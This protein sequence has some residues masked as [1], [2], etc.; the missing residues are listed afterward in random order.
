LSKNSMIIQCAGCGTRFKFDETLIRGEGVW[1]RCSQCKNVFFQENVLAPGQVQMVEEPAAS[2]DEHA[3]DLPDRDAA[4]FIA[5]K[6]RKDHGTLKKVAL[7]ACLLLLILAG[8]MVWLTPG[9]LLNALPGGS[10]V[11]QY[12]S[13]GASRPSSSVGIDLID[14]RDH[15]IKS[16]QGGDLMVVSGTAV[17]RNGYPVSKLRVRA[18]LLNAAGQS[19]GEAES[20]G[21]NVL[22]DENLSKLTAKEIREKLSVSPGSDAANAK[23]APGGQVPFRIVFVDPPKSA[24]EFIV[25]TASLERAKAN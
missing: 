24:V 11:A 6:G 18:K 16:L 22:S 13:I 4:V 20:C 10:S 19:V 15:F 9:T 1:V 8:L 3:E 25:E 14:V 23:T 17:N 5:A 2:A 12:F 21:G 7:G